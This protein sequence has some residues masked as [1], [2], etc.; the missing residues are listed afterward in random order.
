M[1]TLEKEKIF[2]YRDI[3]K[4]PSEGWYE[5]VNGRIK[6]FAPTGF[7]HGF[8][9]SSILSFLRE[10]L[11]KMGY[12]VGGE[13]GILISKKPLTIRGADI[14]FIKK[15]RL[16]EIPKDVLEIAP[17]LIIEIVSPSNSFTE[18]EEK[19]MTISVLESQRLFL[20]TRQQKKFF[21]MK[22]TKE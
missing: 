16:K 13:V 18:L 21:F 7:E 8:F 1:Q 15:D 20:L 2:T 6:K 9:E 4:L 11:K 3:G 10:K 12:V 17:D 22:K 19:K 5:I 14:V